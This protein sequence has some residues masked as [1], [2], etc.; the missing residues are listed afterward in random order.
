MANIEKKVPLEWI[1]ELDVTQEMVEY[2]RPLIQNPS[3]EESGIPRYF[4]LERD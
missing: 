4:T 1:G 3:S 2:L